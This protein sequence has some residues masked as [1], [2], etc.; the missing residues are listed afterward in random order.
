MRRA[1]LLI[2]AVRS[3]PGWR[4]ELG[5]KRSPAPPSSSTSP[6]SLLLLF[7]ITSIV[8]LPPFPSSQLRKTVWSGHANTLVFS[9]ADD[10]PTSD[11]SD[12]YF[13]LFPIS[14]LSNKASLVSSSLLPSIYISSEQDCVRSFISL[15]RHR[16]TEAYRLQDGEKDYGLA[17]FETA[18]SLVTARTVTA[19]THEELFDRQ[20]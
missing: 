3:V 2:D 14:H 11:W 9:S 12:H 8:H 15:G 20:I 16:A 1:A 7:P 5:A 18:S 6:R 4:G 19:C 13:S 10:L 17:S